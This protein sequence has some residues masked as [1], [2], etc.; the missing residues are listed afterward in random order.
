MDGA[1]LS[2]FW[3]KGNISECDVAWK[4]SRVYLAQLVSRYMLC[5]QKGHVSLH[6]GQLAVPASSTHT[7]PL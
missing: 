4:K 5:K 6:M 3:G 7:G 2:V 1:P